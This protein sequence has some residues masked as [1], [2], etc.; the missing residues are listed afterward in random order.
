M[1]ARAEPRVV[2][3]NSDMAPMTPAQ[4]F[5]DVKDFNSRVVDVRLKFNDVPIEIPM[6]RIGTTTNWKAQLTPEQLQMLAISGD[7][8]K[9]KATIT[10]KDLDGNS[11]KTDQPLF[12][13]VKAPSIARYG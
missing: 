8:V 7:T 13:T 3:L 4:V 10:A 12:V 2:I 9:Y 11:T 5:A 6:E 1:N